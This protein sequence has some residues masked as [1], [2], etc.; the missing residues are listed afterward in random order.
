MK[1]GIISDS[2][3]NVPNIQSAVGYFNSVGVAAVLHCGDFVSPFSLFPFTG[4]ECEKL[5]MVFGNNDGEKQGIKELAAQNGWLIG[6]PPMELELHGRKIVMLH[7]PDALGSFRASGR[8]QVI[9]YGHTHR[10]VVKKENGV[11]IINPG[12]GGGW[13]S[14]RSTVA[15]ADLAAME[16]E[17]RTIEKT[18][19]SIS[20]D[21]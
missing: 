21:G 10:P 20:L 1:V 8:H 9:A 6:K 16:A 11:L 2:H 17:I 18:G 5:Y 3:D 15:V 14:G 12:E 7:E 4:L 13:T 19:D